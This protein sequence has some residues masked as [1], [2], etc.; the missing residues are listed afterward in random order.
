MNGELKAEILEIFK[1]GAS[2]PPRKET[3]IIEVSYMGG[4]LVYLIFVASSPDVSLHIQFDNDIIDLPSIRNMWER[5]SMTIN[6]DF[7]VV[8]IYDTTNNKYG[9]RLSGAVPFYYFTKNFKI[10]AKNLTDSTVTVDY[11][12][13]IEKHKPSQ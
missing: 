4:Y 9:V 8:H 5:L 6:R 11:F 1:C 2:I 10:Y 7:A 3:T 12:V 13:I